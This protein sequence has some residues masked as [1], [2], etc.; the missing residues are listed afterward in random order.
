MNR[1][2][3]ATRRRSWLFVPGNR[4][5]FLE[6]IADL[7]LDV[8]IFDLE[9][10]VA[11]IDGVFP[12]LEDFNGLERDGMLARRL[13]FDGKTLLHPSQIDGVNRCFSP[14]LEDVMRAQEI[15][16]AF[17]EAIGRGD[18]E[19]A[20]RGQLVDLPVVLRARRTIGAAASLTS[21][22]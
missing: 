21:D 7:P 20:V 13:G 4:P 6:K 15:L 22:S 9:D 18:G 11:A 19:A 12:D 1:G 10:G 8:A 2:A 5:R 14:T 17:E 3:T 16:E